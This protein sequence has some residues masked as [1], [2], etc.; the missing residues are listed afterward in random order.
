M[1]SKATCHKQTETRDQQ[2][3]D[4]KFLM[5]NDDGLKR[6][7]A[8]MGLSTTI[9]SSLRKRLIMA[10][11]RRAYEFYYKFFNVSVQNVDFDKLALEYEQDYSHAISLGLFAPGGVQEK[12]HLNLWCISRV[13]S[14]Q[15]YVESGA[16]IGTSLHAFI[17][18]PGIQKIFAIDPNLHQLKIPEKSIPGAELIS[19]KDFSQLT[20]DISGMRSL[21]Y[22][23]DHIDTADRILQAY[24]KGFR[25]VL[26]DD[27]NGF[28]GICQ[29]LYPA[30][31]TVPM[32]INAEILSLDDELS[33]TY[34]RSLTTDLKSIIKRIFWRE[35]RVEGIRVT[36]KITQELI[37]KCLEAKKLIR[38]YDVIPNLG[39]FVPQSRPERMV[40]T[41]KFL[42]ELNRF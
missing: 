41:S 1:L 21:V 25:Y 23:D 2:N 27:S 16:F 37:D 10:A 20:I 40:D 32:I 36:L 39:D 13:F 30:I 34:N 9:S 29:R 26:F 38:K 11:M 33:W 24:E 22:F 3:M 7:I 35:G 31:P 8:D 6:S 5:G 4:R 42:I 17:N 12:D 19:D 28:E 18:S 15:V 14:P